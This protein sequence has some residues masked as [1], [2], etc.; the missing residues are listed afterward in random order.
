MEVIPDESEKTAVF[1]M[2]YL[3]DTQIKSVDTQIKSVA[4]T[5]YFAEERFSLVTSFRIHVQ[6]CYINILLKTITD[7]GACVSQQ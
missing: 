4:L 5:F 3:G 1:D 2:L 6:F 7:T